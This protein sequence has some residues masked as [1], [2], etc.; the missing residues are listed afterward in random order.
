MNFHL[1]Q[2]YIE[3]R[4]SSSNLNIVSAT[5]RQLESIIRLAEA[6]AR[7]RFSVYVQKQDVEEA[8]RLIEV[9]T[10]KAAIDPKTGKIDMNQLGTGTSS[11]SRANIDEICTVIRKSLEDNEEV[12]SKGLLF[13]SLMEDVRRRLLEVKRNNKFNSNNNKIIDEDLNEFEFREALKTLENQD[14]IFLT[15]NQRLPVIKYIDKRR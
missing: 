10:Q 1:Y 6:R 11:L 3:M 12:A 4:N 14:I 8:V 15:G 5:P 2:K 13:S 9:A 7:L